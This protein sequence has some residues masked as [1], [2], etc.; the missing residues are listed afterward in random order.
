MSDKPVILP[1]HVFDAIDLRSPTWRAALRGPEEAVLFGPTN[2]AQPALTNIQ[3]PHDVAPTA[4]SVVQNWYATTDQL[5]R[6]FEA[7]DTIAFEQ[8]SHWTMLTLSVGGRPFATRS[9]YELLRRQSRTVAPLSD[10]EQGN[11]NEKLEALH[12]ED[13]ARM[14]YYEHERASATKPPVLWEKL[15]MARH[16]PFL[17]IARAAKRELNQAPFATVPNGVAVCVD[18]QSTRS[19]TDRLLTQLERDR[20][21]AAVW[22]H[23]EGYSVY[24]AA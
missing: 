18:V 24:E 11:D 16:D 14:F 8:W 23:L 13:L 12:L 17:A 9:L 1:L 21:P 6:G 22:I 2:L 4:R 19:T 3:Q 5:P 20:L 10:D 15:D 7:A